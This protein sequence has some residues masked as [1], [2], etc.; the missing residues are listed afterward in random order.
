MASAH[1]TQAS[2]ADRQRADAGRTP[3]VIP[4]IVGA[5]RPSGFDYRSERRRS[6]ASVADLRLGNATDG[7]PAD[8][9]QAF[10]K[11]ARTSLLRKAGSLVR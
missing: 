11:Q 10:V 8:N 3:G 6:R 1:S 2:T 9:D 5:C 7:G 4:M